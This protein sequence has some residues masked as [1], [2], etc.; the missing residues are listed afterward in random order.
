MEGS[1][2]PGWVDGV[3]WN[4]GDGARGCSSGDDADVLPAEIVDLLYGGEE[5]LELSLVCQDVPM[6]AIYEI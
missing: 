1:G 4:G 2:A 5:C 6:N 3:V